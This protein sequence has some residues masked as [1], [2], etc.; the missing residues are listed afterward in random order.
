MRRL[1][2]ITILLF[3]VTAKAVTLGDLL[4][5]KSY[6]ESLITE[7][8]AQELAT[9][10]S[11]DNFKV[12]ARLKIERVKPKKQSKKRDPISDLNLTYINPEE[13]YKSYSGQNDQ[14]EHYLKEFLVTSI[15][16]T[17]GL[18]PAL[19]E[20][21]KNEISTWLQDSVSSEFGKTGKV[22]IATIQDRPPEPS[23]EPP[24]KTPMDYVSELQDLIGYVLLTFAA[25]FAV[26]LW[27]LLS[28]KASKGDNADLNLNNKME[29]QSQPHEQN[30]TQ[31]NKEQ[32]SSPDEIAEKEIERQSQKI[33]EILPDLTSELDV[34]IKEWCQ[35][36][37]EG[38]AQ[39]AGLAELSRK[40]VGPLPIP[41]EFEKEI[42]DTFRQMR[43][44][45][46]NQRLENINKV[47]W[48]LLST[49]H[50]GSR[51]LH[52]PFSFIADAPVGTMREVLAEND[53]RLQTIT[54]LFMS[55][56]RR[57]EYLVTLTEED[58][59]RLLDTASK[60]VDIGENELI[61]MEDKLSPHFKA[62]SN[63][64]KVA[65]SV[66]LARL[67]GSLSIKES[68]TLLRNISG[69]SAQDLKSEYP[70]VAFL[71]EWPEAPLK[72]LFRVT[73]NEELLN[74]L[75]IRRDLQARFL[76]LVPPMTRTIISD[77]LNSESQ[78]SEE[79]Q[80]KLLL[81]MQEK[82]KDLVDAGEVNLKDI[83]KHQS[84]HPG[85]Q[86]AA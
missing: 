43:T 22:T 57:K 71:E 75:L 81:S 23:P 56:D 6:L 21:T 32:S 66:T 11:S 74:Y 12:A 51:S 29:I 54:T 58:K 52:T 65:L 37:K 33:L 47:L 2:W 67:V 15:E 70:S 64:R 83:F 72:A 20:K 50:L 79:E 63:E 55:E 25:L 4:Q 41:A 34:V 10:L 44:Q 5:A 48:D 36:G 68:C 62:D 60:L 78:L 77:D 27:K 3:V 69:P 19:E 82:I 45:T 24:K 9:H 59:L 16:V 80:E 40:S 49:L 14:T 73:T 53:I 35:K 26:I 84:E 31:L 85:G 39:V 86:R 7:K 61:A 46:P 28:E 13:L 42:A 8:Y 38:F 76:K 30:Q 18:N 1:T 17:V